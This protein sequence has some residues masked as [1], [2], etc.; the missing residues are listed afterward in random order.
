MGEL[1][2][3]PR[4][5]LRGPDL[6]VL[7]PQQPVGVGARAH[8]EVRQAGQHPDRVP[9]RRHGLQPL[10]RILG[11]AR[12]RPQGDRAELRTAAGA[13]RERPRHEP[14]RAT[15]CRLCG[16]CRKPWRR[17]STR[18]RHRSWSRTPSA[19]TRSTG[20]SGTNARSGTA[21]SS[22]CRDSNSSN[23]FRCS[24]ADR[25]TSCNAL[26]R[27]S[28]RRC[29][30]GGISAKLLSDADASSADCERMVGGDRR[31]GR[32]SHCVTSARCHGSTLE[33]G[34]PI[35]IVAAR[36]Q[37]A[38]LEGDDSLTDFILCT[39]RSRWSSRSGLRVGSQQAQT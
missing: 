33:T 29:S 18:W 14:G 34:L 17:R 24:D 11:A 16:A 21:I 25:G 31:T 27:N 2:Q 38:L 26:A 6:H 39:A 9:S 4:P 10:P 15:G 36:D 1:L 30:L 35:L 23:T 20:S 12:R 3:A 22:T 19:S 7:G 5:R 32:R 8:G 37:L 28:P 13:H